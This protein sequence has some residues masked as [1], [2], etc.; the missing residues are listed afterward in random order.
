MSERDLTIRVECYAGYRGEE[1]PRR[2]YL[3]PCRVEVVEVLDRWLAPDH[4]YFKLKS[5]D[6]A[7][8]IV[9]HDVSSGHWELT[10]FSAS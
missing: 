4:R 8:Y 5:D 9:R 7:I 1:T 2:F 6:G 10:M 3:G